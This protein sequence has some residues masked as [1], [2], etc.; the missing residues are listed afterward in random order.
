V[1]ITRAVVSL[2]FII[3]TQSMVIVITIDFCY[4]FIYWFVNKIVWGFREL[5][6][7]LQ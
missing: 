5:N 4:L 3:R 2:L 6:Y 1:R 7:L